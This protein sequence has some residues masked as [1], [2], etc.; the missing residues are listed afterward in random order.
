M[1]KDDAKMM[2]E[3]LAQMVSSDK[4]LQEFFL[5][6]MIRATKGRLDK[7]LTL[8]EAAARLGKSSSWLYKN[9]N[10]FNYTKRGISKSSYLVF[11]NLTL[12]DDY[13][14]YLENRV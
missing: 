1:T 10:L 6:E 8:K 9:K 2:I 4:E 14:N 3:L 11:D 5:K 7:S 12:M 13:R